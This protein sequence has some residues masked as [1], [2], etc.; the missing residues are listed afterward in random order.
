[1]DLAYGVFLSKDP[2]GFEG[3]IN[4]YA[5]VKNNPINWTDP[6]G[7]KRRNGESFSNCMNRCLRENYGDTYDWASIFSLLG[8]GSLAVEI[9]SNAATTVIDQAA[10]DIQ[11]ASNLKGATQGGSIL[12][13][14]NAAEQGARNAGKIGVARGG[15]SLVSKASS[16]VTVG[17]T[18]FQIGALSYC[19]AECAREEKCEER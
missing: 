15:L 14:L 18:A 4:V 3:G 7:L 5:Y 1:M 16:V 13:R 11:K 6:D 12:N 17:A 8:I 9:G 10:S 2:I 19:A